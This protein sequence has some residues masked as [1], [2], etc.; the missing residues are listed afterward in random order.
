M[1]SSAAQRRTAIVEILSQSTEA[2]SASVLASR[3]KVSR[4]I[5]VG[6]VA[7]LR[8]SGERII[9][10]PR[11]YLLEK[12]QPA[13]GDSRCIRTIAC[14]HHLGDG[15]AR[16]L[17]TVVDN[18]GELLDVVVEHP[19]YGQISAPLKLASRYDVD[20][21]LEKVDHF[22]AQPLAA[23]TDGIHLHNIACAGEAVFQR[24][25]AALEEQGILLKRE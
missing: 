7:L 8:A 21:F 10:T 24:I 18:G 6:D 22:K 25:T 4:Q 9:A 23:L 12:S 20:A 1:G 2:L 17:Y 19:L 13:Q 3:L 16:E 5:V 15:L 11:G 14:E